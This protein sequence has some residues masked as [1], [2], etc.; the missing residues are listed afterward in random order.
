MFAGEHCHSNFYSTVHGAYLSGKDAA[1]CVANA[2]AAQLL[3]QPTNVPTSDGGVAAPRPSQDEAPD[4]VV[5][6]GSSEESTTEVQAP[7]RGEVAT[8]EVQAPARG[9]LAFDSEGSP[10]LSSWLHGISL[11]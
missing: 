1:D 7:A 6:S 4:N 3:H 10:N 11:K 2:A 9:L 5:P 8:T